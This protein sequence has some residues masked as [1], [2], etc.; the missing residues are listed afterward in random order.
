[1][2]LILGEQE[3]IVKTVFSEENSAGLQN[4]KRHQPNDRRTSCCARNCEGSCYQ[5]GSN[6]QR[7]GIHFLHVQGRQ[8][9][10]TPVGK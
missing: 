6:Q 8:R 1:M 5:D 7:Y 9:E 4:G 10:E 3:E 2:W